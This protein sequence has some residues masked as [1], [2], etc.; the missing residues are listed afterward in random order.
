MNDQDS[1]LTPL[2][3]AVPYMMRFGTI[4]TARSIGKA[5]F[6]PLLRPCSPDTSLAETVRNTHWLL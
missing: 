1:P 3:D 2:P 4:R 6:T 5:K